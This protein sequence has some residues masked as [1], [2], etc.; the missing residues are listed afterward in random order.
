MFVANTLNNA[1]REGARQ[2]VVTPAAAMNISTLEPYVK[3]LI[4]I[5]QTGL[6][7][8]VTGTPASGNP[9]TVSIALPFKTV[10]PNLIPALENITLKGEATMRYE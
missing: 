4:P 1:A 7:V 8:A 2:A 10:V 9:I 6:S 3:T 5:D